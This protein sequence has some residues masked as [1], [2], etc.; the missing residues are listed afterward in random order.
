[1]F[2]VSS[3]PL[4]SPAVVSCVASNFDKCLICESVPAAAMGV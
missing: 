4:P 1:M 2:L 3:T